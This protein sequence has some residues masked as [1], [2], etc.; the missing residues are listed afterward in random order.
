MSNNGKQGEQL[1]EQIM[2]CRNYK[3]E[4]VS[5][6][7]DYWRQDI[8]FVITSLTTGAVKSFEIKWDSKIHKTDNLYLE[9]ANKNSEGALGWY[10][11]CKADYLAYGD[12]ITGTFYIIPLD[13]LRERVEQLPKRVAYCGDDSAGYLV[14]LKDISDIT[15]TL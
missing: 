11:F 14:S 6:N 8:D 5:N 9:I 7:P 4:N 3:I 15:Q 1:F 13:K 10:K 2:S 12:A